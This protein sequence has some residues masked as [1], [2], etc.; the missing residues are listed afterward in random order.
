MKKLGRMTTS[1]AAIAL[2]LVPLLA[3]A[4]S[5]SSR[6]NQER[7]AIGRQLLEVQ[8]TN[9]PSVLQYYTDDIEYHDPIVDI[10]GID[11]MTEF[12]ARL[13][14][15]TPDLVTTVEDETC[16]NGVYSAAWEMTGFFAGVP[17]MA[18]GM[19]II[20]FRPRETQAYYQRDYYSEGDIMINIPGLDEAMIAFRTFYRC[21]VDPTFDCPPGKAGGDGR[22]QDGASGAQSPP[23]A[24]AFGLQQNAPNPFN[25]STTISFAVPAGGGAVTLR[26]YDIA[27][28]LVR[29]LV[30][31]HQPAGDQSV[32]W[33]GRD[34][35]GRPAP[36]GIYRYRMTAPDY[37]EQ[38][39]M[40]LLK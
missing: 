34:D 3:S 18:K 4:E 33:D 17:Y 19:S 12:L 6:I 29:T 36:S 35:Q 32:T 26:I 11:T 5:D 10:E 27:G 24:A 39:S 30:D 9:W 1:L 8:S 25:P 20:K 38:R 16:I 31:G 40:V 7:K 23:V 21:A 15:S 13:F 22:V 37:S 2:L 28:R 14:E